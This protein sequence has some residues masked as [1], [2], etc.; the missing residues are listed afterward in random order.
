MIRPQIWSGS[1]SETRHA[2]CIIPEREFYRSMVRLKG[3]DYS[4]VNARTPPVS[5]LSMIVAFLGR[6]HLFSFKIKKS[7]NKISAEKTHHS[8][9]S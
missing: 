1:S 7:E 9:G 6:F 2:Q 5:L 8:G 4:L 3:L